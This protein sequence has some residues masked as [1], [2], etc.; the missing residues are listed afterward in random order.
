MEFHL[1]GLAA[2]I[3]VHQHIRAAV[4]DALVTGHQAVV[5]GHPVIAR[6]HGNEGL[7]HQL[8]RHAVVVAHGHLRFDLHGLGHGRRVRLGGYV[9]AHFL[10][11]DAARRVGEQHQVIQAQL[12]AGVDVAKLG[13]LQAVQQ[14][15][16]LQGDLAVLV[17]GIGH[18][19]HSVHHPGILRHIQPVAALIAGLG[20]LGRDGLLPLAPLEGKHQRRQDFR[21]ERRQ[22]RQRQQQRQRK[23]A[24]A[25]KG[26]RP[27]KLF[28]H[29]ASLAR[30]LEVAKFMFRLY[31]GN[32]FSSMIARC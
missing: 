24:D 10:A 32:V 11:R 25:A 16:V 5:G 18:Q 13:E 30:S 21:R 31:Y 6:A 14:P 29:D 7:L 1:R 28:H 9:E 17:I 23:R 19:Q 22:R 3:A 12:C 27:V 20:H 15:P 8:A 2:A 26:N 4:A